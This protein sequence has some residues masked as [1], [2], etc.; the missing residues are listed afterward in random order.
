MRVWIA[1]RPARL[2]V[3]L[4]D[5]LEVRAGRVLVGDRADP[6]QA[7]RCVLVEG[8]DDLKLSLAHRCR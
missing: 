8:A 2:V 4:D 5:V 7:G 3:A 1:G 6:S